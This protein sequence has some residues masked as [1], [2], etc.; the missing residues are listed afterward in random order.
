MTLLVAALAAASVALALPA[1]SRLAAASSLPL[2][3]RAETAGLLRRW[4][5]LW[6]LLAFAGGAVFA[7]GPVSV[8][9]G[10]AAATG[11]WWAASRAESPERRRRREQARRELPHLVEL[12]AAAL[13]AGAA[14]GAALGQVRAA[15]PGAAA[16]ELAGVQA[17]L[18][19]GRSPHDVWAEPADHPALAPLGRSMARAQVSG[20]PVVDAVR[21]LADELA[22]RARSEVEDRARTVGVKAAVPLGLCLLPAFLLLGIVPMVAG[23]ISAMDW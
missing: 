16:D 11:V 23:A 17:G 5:V 13:A 1:R 9:V 3:D 14:P 12:Y 20:A 19:L 2:P 10:C 21:L 8:P 6:A 4:W 22:E 7:P 15:L 18:D